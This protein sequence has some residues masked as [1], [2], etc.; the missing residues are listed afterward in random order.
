MECAQTEL[1][2]VYVKSKNVPLSLYKKR[3]K[4]HWFYERIKR[5]CHSV[6]CLMWGNT[7]AFCFSQILSR[8]VSWVGSMA[9]SV[10]LKCLM[11]CWHTQ[12]LNNIV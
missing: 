3:E 8:Q 10:L 1:L 9:N 5:N 12:M 11:W 4:S 6:E 7:I 2:K